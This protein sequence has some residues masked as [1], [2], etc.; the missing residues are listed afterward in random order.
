MVKKGKKVIRS[1][2]I[3]ACRP[4]AVSQLYT[5]PGQLIAKEGSG[6]HRDDQVAPGV[7]FHPLEETYIMRVVNEREELALVS[8]PG[9]VA[10][11]TPHLVDVP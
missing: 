11:E 3:L 8:I 10:Q 9:F 4:S 7:L 1:R 6:V 5:E 2:G